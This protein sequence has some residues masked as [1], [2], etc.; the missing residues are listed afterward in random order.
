MRTSTFSL[1]SLPLFLLLFFFF[2]TLKAITAKNL[3]PETCKKCVQD[4]PNL[5]YKFC[6]T[7]LQAAP[8]SS[9]AD[10]RQLGIISMNLIR[11]NMTS[12]RQYIKQL[13]KNRKLDKFLR[14]YLEVCLE[15]YSDAIPDIKQALRYY[16]AK[17]YRDANVRVTGVYDAPVTCEDG[18]HERKGLVSPL[19]KRNNDAVQLSAIALSIIDMLGSLGFKLI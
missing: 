4:D 19:T 16:K 10:V 15:L 6:V 5:S 11:Q 2:F 18:F 17:Q 14:A 8:N 3:I 1:T 12:T 13:M 9:S 7:S